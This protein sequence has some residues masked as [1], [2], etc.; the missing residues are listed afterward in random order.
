MDCLICKIA[1]TADELNKKIRCDLCGAHLCHGCSGLSA[2]EVRV[3]QLSTKRTLKFECSGCVGEDRSRNSHILGIP[4]RD[5]SAD[6]V[7]MLRSDFFSKVDDL[8]S[9]I[10]SL[11]ESNIQLVR[12]VSPFMN[13]PCYA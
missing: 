5:S 4:H 12:V 7:A 13:M 2:T 9:Q 8:A 6:I 10:T 3:M 1:L 11:K